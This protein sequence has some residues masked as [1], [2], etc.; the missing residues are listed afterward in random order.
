MENFEFNKQTHTYKL[1]DKILPSVTQII[2]EV[3]FYN[4]YSSV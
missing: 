2:N 3:L 4:K 1:N